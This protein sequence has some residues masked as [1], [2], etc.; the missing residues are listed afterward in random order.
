MYGTTLDLTDGKQ[1]SYSRE[2]PGHG[3][4]LFL[5]SW[6]YHGGASEPEANNRG[7]A[8]KTTLFQIPLKQPAHAAGYLSLLTEMKTNCETEK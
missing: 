7:N 4:K 8:W 2:F 3:L 6:E 5:V 1:T